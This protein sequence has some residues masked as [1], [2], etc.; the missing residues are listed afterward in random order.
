MS[1]GS[2]QR[3]FT[4][5]IGLLIEYAYQNGYEL[6]FGDAYRDPRLHGQVGEKK[7]YGATGSLHKQRLA[8]DFNLFRDGKFLQQTDDHKPLGEYWESLGGSWGGR[9]NDG[10]HYSLEHEGRK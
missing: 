7:G 9:F 1:L 4:K 3:R 6:T 5:M 10:N 2:K 8:V